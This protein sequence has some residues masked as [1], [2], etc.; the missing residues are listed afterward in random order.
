MYFYISSCIFLSEKNSIQEFNSL[1]R[2][3]KSSC[4]A[5]CP[6]AFVPL[7]TEGNILV[8]DVLA[9]CYASFHHDLAHIA[10]TPIQ[11]FPEIIQWIFGD[12]V[13]PSAFVKTTK[14]IGS[15]ILP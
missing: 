12:E 10:M 13:G 5:F 6:G 11:W 7:T 2:N 9:S 4:V 8:D 3:N 1:N 15:L 14:Y